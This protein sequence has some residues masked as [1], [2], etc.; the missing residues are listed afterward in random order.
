V[1]FAPVSFVSEYGDG[2]GVVFGVPVGA[3]LGMV[4]GGT[5]GACKQPR[6]RWVDASLVPLEVRDR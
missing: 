6:E 4:F 3:A 1:P 2:M 5:V